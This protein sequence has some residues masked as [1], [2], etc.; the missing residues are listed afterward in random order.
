MGWTPEQLP[1]LAGKT[2]AITGGNSG[3]GFEAAMILAAHGARVVITARNEAKGR[4]A[5]ARI[6][7][8]V[9][10]ADVD[11]V[12]LDLADPDSV[13]SAAEGLQAACLRLDAIIN[14]A[15]VMQTPEI[16]TREGF[17]LQ[18]ATNHLGHVRLDSAL[19][20][21]LESSS[22]RIVSVTSIAHKYGRIDLEDL[23]FT[24]RRYD[25]LAAYAQSKL[26][27]LLFALELHRRLQ[28]R[29]SQVA[30]VPC[31]PGYSATNLQSAGV[32]MKGGSRAWRWIYAVTNA[33]L[34]QSAV[35]G[36]YPLVLASAD[37][38]AKPGTYYGP[39]ALGD[40]RGPVGESSV[41]GRARDQE[42]GRRLWE[43]T[44]SLVGPFFRAA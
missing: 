36:A 10:T 41:A 28:A 11:V 43:K 21:R 38:T 7:N 3:I 2:Y 22:G 5:L 39:T 8:A 27:N 4:T 26:A 9:A 18:L 30:S 44:E 6:R 19:F 31:H 34:A 15:G 12:L 16:R 17:E 1:D 20:P 29:G 25:P 32:G 42:L 24:T 33:V 23:M 14:N 35:R 40:T 37:P 13:R